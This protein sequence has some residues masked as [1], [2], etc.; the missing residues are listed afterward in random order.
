M[1]ADLASRPRGGHRAAVGTLHHVQRAL[2]T[3]QAESP[4]RY[5]RIAGLL[6]RAPGKYC[7]DTE[8]FTITAHDGWII[9]SAGW[10]ALGMTLEVHVPAR[11]ILDFM[12]G[13]TTVERLI[14]RDV[15]RITGNPSSLLALDEATRVLA[16]AAIESRALQEEFDAFQR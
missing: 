13:T 5:A 7:V 4:K 3:L 11:A 14:Q 10:R 8:R 15:L 1:R 16:R 12:D 2:A 9:A 6:R